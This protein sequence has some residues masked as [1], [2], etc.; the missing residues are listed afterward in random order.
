MVI[1][2]LS[3]GCVLIEMH[4]K[5][6]ST[7]PICLTRGVVCLRI[8]SSTLWPF[9]EVFLPTLIEAQT[10]SFYAIASFKLFKFGAEV[11]L[12]IEPVSG[13]LRVN[14]VPYSPSLG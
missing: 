5:L 13:L 12:S 10:G 8:R 7:T 3:S 14:L 6:Q 9:L 1:E 4:L 11:E 2:H